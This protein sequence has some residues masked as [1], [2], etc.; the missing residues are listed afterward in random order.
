MQFFNRAGAILRSE[1][2]FCAAALVIG[3]AGW[4][5]RRR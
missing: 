4:I 3:V 5:V 1:L 2:P